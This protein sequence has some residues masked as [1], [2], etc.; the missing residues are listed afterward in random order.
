MKNPH[1]ERLLNYL[2]FLHDKKNHDYAEE[3]SPFSNF[4]FAAQETG[5]SVEKVIDVLISIK[6]A[7]LIQLMERG[8]EPQNESVV[9]T[10]VDELNYRAIK[11]S[12]YLKINGIEKLG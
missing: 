3:G 10:L 7:R 8:K 11:L 4:E 1:F 12:Y 6:R 5:L 9:D 2:Q